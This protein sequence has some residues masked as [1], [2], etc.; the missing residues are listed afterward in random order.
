MTSAMVKI[1]F[2][3][4]KRPE[5]VW[6]AE[7]LKADFVGFNLYPKSPRCVPL[8]DLKKLAGE[9]KTA[10]KVLVFVNSTLAEVARAVEKSG[11]D[12]IQLHGNE[13]PR[14]CS[15]V[16]VITG[17]PVIKAFRLATEKD[18]K[19]L[20]KYLDYA[21][22]F[23]LD[24]RAEG[25]YGGTGQP[26]PWDM[27]IKAKEFGKPVFLAGGLNCENVAEAC[28]K[29]MPFAVDVA[30]GVEEKTGVKNKEK[31]ALFIQKVKGGK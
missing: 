22:Y 19:P 14:F 11:A 9:V 30:G 7:E 27:A 8:K 24:A 29:V 5:E 31:M 10:K 20:E 26:F 25:L 6:W 28:R 18:L 15:Q 12:G 3:G 13:T 16:R 17:R 2:C 4:L 23:L 21:D 1:K